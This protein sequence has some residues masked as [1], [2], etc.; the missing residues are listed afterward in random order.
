MSK[1]VVDTVFHFKSGLD[2]QNPAVAKEIEEVWRNLDARITE[3]KTTVAG[4]TSE[5]TADQFNTLSDAVSKVASD[6]K[7][8]KA[9]L[10]GLLS[11]SLNSDGTILIVSTPAG[12]KYVTLSNTIP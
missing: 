3:L 2:K 9:S 7:T 8:F 5:V 11:L 4:T 1:R 6:L 12:P 10:S